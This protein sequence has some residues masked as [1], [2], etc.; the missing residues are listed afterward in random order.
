MAPEQIAG[1]PVDHRADI[2]ALGCSSTSRLPGQPPFPATT[3]WRS[4]SPTATRLGRGPRSSCL[5]LPTALD[6]SWRRRWRSSRRALRERRPARRGPGARRPRRGAAGRRTTAA[7]G[8]ASDGRATRRLPR[9][10]R[11]R[12]AAIVAACVALAVA[13][14]SRRPAPQRGRTRWSSPPVRSPRRGR[15]GPRRSRADPPRGRPLPPLGGLQRR[16]RALRDRSGDQPAGATA[17][18]GGRR[19][20]S[21]AVAFDSIWALNRDSNTLLRLEHLNRSA[22]IE[23]PVG[24]NP[25]DVAFDKHWVWVA[26]QRRRHGLANRPGHQSGRRH[27]RRR[28]RSQRDRDGSRGRLGDERRRRLGVQDRPRAARRWSASR[29]RSASGPT[30]SRWATATCG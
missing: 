21:V 18:A 13:A 2:Y 5:R 8:A 24:A 27:R 28:L 29:S 23:I 1:D 4:S 3:T 30:S 6:G 9:P 26:N 20:V 14:A 16:L 7:P 19:P 15:H 22:P 25:S 11:R 12:T 10:R 17:G